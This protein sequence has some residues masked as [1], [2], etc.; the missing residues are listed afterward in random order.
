[1][2][3]YTAQELAYKNGYEA[4]KKDAVKHGWWVWF[5]D[6]ECGLYRCSCCHG[7]TGYP[8]FYCHYCGAKME[9]KT[10]GMDE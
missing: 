5:E 6:E 8:S 3:K 7:G 4:G 10:E 2:D 9:L 1:M